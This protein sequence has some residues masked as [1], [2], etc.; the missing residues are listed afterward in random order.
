MNITIIDVTHISEIATGTP[1]TV[2]SDVSTDPN[3]IVNMAR[4]I[5]AIPYEPVVFIPATL[6]RDIVD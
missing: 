2:I 1:V 6:K 3:S 4:T 5:H